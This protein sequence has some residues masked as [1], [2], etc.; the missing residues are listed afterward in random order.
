MNEVQFTAKV[1]TWI[2]L[3]LRDN[4][5]L[6]FSEADIEAQAKG[7]RKRRDMTLK[8]KDSNVVICTMKVIRH[9]IL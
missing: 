4:P 7:S 9:I 1:T 6:P 8:D 2:A 3:I 5:S